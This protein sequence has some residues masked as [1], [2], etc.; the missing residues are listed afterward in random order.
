MN[1]TPL[2]TVPG[3]TPAYVNRM[4]AV[5]ITTAEQIAA[6][7]ATPRGVTSLA[8]QL[9]VADAE[10]SRLAEAARAALPPERR[11][12]L[13]VPVDTSDYGLGARRPRNDEPGGHEA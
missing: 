13:D 3:W 8:E 11:A 9:G 7:A 12:E 2:G 1:D 4:K 5:W 10:A 6:L